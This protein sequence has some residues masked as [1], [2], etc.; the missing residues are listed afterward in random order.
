MTRIPSS[1]SSL[2]KLE[3]LAVFFSSF[4]PSGYSG[5]VLLQGES[6]QGQSRYHQQ[7]IQLHL[8]FTRYFAYFSIF[9][10]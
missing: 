10:I 8:I 7:Y 6:R 5:R 4:A 1:P 9:F 3:S 2:G